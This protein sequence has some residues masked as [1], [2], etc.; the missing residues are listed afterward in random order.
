MEDSLEIYELAFKQQYLDNFS[1]DENE[2]EVK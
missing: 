2:Y 1:K